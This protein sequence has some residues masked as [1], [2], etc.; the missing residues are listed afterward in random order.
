MRL[1]PHLQRRQWGALQLRKAVDK[2]ET[3]WLTRSQ[4]LEMAFDAVMQEGRICSGGIGELRG[5]GQL[6]RREVLLACGGFNEDTV[7]DDLDLSFRLLLA[8]EAIGVIWNPPVQEE[9]VTRWG[10]LLRQRQRWAEGGL[11]RYL[12]YWPALISNKLSIKQRLDLLVFFLLQY[13]L[14]VAIYGDLFAALAWRELPVLW[15]LSISTVGFSA[16]AIKR[17]GSRFSD[18]PALPSSSGLTLL[19]A[20]TYLMHW[21]LVIPWVS[22]KMAFKPKRLVWAKTAHVGL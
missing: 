1:L 7:T 10:A 18:G 19:I 15:P 8:G 16:L 4:A 2:A 12:D 17:A 9:P 6:L 21:F 5:N 3:S 14:P 11:Q 20:N 13:A 22:L